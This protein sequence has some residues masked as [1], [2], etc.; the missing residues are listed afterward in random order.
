MNLRVQ[1]LAELFILHKEVFDI[2]ILK[3]CYFHVIR[4]CLQGGFQGK[5]TDTVDSS[6]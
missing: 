3:T 4:F 5:K 1:L 6:L 2:F